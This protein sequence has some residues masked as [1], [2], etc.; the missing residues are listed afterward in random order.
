MS[1]VHE[2]P[3]EIAPPR[4]DVRFLARRRAATVALLVALMVALLLT[5]P[6]LH[7]V[8]DRFGDMQAGWVVA[9]LVL[10]L[11]SCLAFVVVF[12]FFFDTVAPALARRIAWT[13]MASGALLPGG[14]VTSLAAGG[15]LMNLAGQSSG[16]IV[17]R[18]SA[19][20][21]LTSAVNVAALGAGGA[22]LATGIGG[23]PHDFLRTAGPIAVGLGAIGVA[24]ALARFAP[25]RERRRRGWPAELAAGIRE[26]ERAATRP[27]WR[28]G[29]A[30]GYLG[31]DIAVLWASLRGLGYAPAIGALVVAYLA[32]YLATWMPIPG[33]LGVLDGGLAGA[34]VLYGMPPAT[35]AAAVLVYHAI[36]LWVPSV[37]GLVAYTLL[38]RKLVQ[39]NAERRPAPAASRDEHIPSP[40]RM[41]A[42]FEPQPV[43]HFARCDSRSLP[44]RDGVTARGA[45]DE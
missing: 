17:R 16:R 42:Q 33:G 8:F 41:A 10:E 5:V 32:G 38:R 24:L 2:E 27:S 35:A 23:G 44:G 26:A 21:F 14:G 22:L 3:T 12:R 30:L 39:P 19:L 45:Q 11:L 1:A 9:A 29:A 15:W 4:F 20:F 25:A 37:G 40:S 28:V 13:E 43:P 34:L 7:E 36:A 31:F 6:S 18:S